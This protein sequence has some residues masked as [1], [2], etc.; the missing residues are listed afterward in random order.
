MST[1]LPRS[2][3]EVGPAPETFWS[4]H[5]RF[6]SDLRPLLVPIDQVSQHPE[7]P[8]SG[9]VE[10]I[11]VSMETVG[12]YRPVYV[13][14][15]TG[16]IVAGN[17]TYAALLSLESTVIPVV[18][19]DLSDEEAIRVLLGDNELARLAIVDQGLLGPLME[20]LLQTEL[21]LLG[22]GYV[23][24]PPPPL[25]D[26]EPGHTVSVSLVGDRLAQWLD[27]PGENDRER[28]LFLL[29]LR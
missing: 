7:N 5:V 1:V 9:D 14:R 10:A 6:H 4:G 16:F 26:I 28:L 24:P 12:C 15:S 19:L 3:G 22:T 18:W 27:V 13:Q 11:A 17:H 21:Q 29:D 25:R 2:E 20:R 8:S 23:D